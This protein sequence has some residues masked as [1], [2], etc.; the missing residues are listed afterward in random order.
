MLITHIDIYS[1]SIPM[2]PFTI[3]TGTMHYAQNIFIRVQTDEGFY[4]VGECSAFPMIV[5]ESQSTCYVMARDF[6]ALWKGKDPLEIDARMQEL[7]LFTAGNSTI[8]SAFDMA[9]YDIAAKAAGMP[10]FQFLGG[11]NQKKLETDLT[12]GIGSPADMADKAIEF[13]K[14][15]VRI[16]KIKLGRSPEEDIE[17]VRLIREAAGKEIILRIDAN[18]GW[19]R[20][21]AEKALVAMGDLNIQFCEQP[22]RTF[23][24][25]LLPG[26]KKISPVPVMADES[27]YNHHDAERLIRT[28]SCSYVNIKLAKTG[29]I[30]EAIS[31][32]RV[33]EKAGIPCMM[34][35]MLESRVALTAFAHFATAFGNVL[36]Y[37]MDTCL[38]GH[39]EDPV[40]GGV[41]Y[42]GYFVELPDSIGIGAD[43]NEDYLSSLD[44]IRV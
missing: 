8:K 16:I 18:Q 10:L 11:K 26:L 15:G 1:F 27:V 31:V 42:N 32:N 44:Q 29:G 7:H 22:M 37:D 5:G 13:V 4:G 24:D 39:K 2:H 30:L 35:G 23:N 34:G 20:P 21:G 33:C 6:A 14:N 12:I 19:D 9:L 17:R 25:H 36:F 43:V 28:D 3:A 40:T 38:L 41:R